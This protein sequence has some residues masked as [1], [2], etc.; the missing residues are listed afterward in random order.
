METGNSGAGRRLMCEYT[1]AIFLQG[2]HLEEPLQC[3]IVPQ[4]NLYC[5]FKCGCPESFSVF[6]KMTMD[7]ELLLFSTRSSRMWSAGQT[8]WVFIDTREIRVL[9]KIHSKT[10]YKM[11]RTWV[12]QTM[13]PTIVFRFSD[14]TVVASCISWMRA[15]LPVL[16]K[17]FFN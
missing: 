10:H 14:S 4:G 17:V 16:G 7:C 6:Q 15:L 12:P 8:F 2:R 9:S 1:S 3:I 13:M 11:W 5:L